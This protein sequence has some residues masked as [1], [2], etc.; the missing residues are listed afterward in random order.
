MKT[1]KEF[2]QEKLISE[3]ER[4]FVQDGNIV[5]IQMQDLLSVI[6]K[7]AKGQNRRVIKIIKRHMQTW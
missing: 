1:S 2:L 4:V 6:H 3:G 7:H 5:I